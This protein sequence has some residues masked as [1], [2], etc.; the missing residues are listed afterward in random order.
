MP[1]TGLPSQIIGHVLRNAAHSDM[2]FGF[3]EFRRTGKN[4]GHRLG[5]DG[6]EMIE[7]DLDLH[8]GCGGH[9]EHLTKRRGEFGP[10]ITAA[11]SFEIE[12]RMT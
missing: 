1:A 6:A 12:K 4:L 9:V 10:E 3:V 5:C 7:G 11:V 2:V 8:S